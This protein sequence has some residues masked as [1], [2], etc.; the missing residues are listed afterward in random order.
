MEQ[1]NIT[2][3]IPIINLFEKSID[4]SLILNLLK[5][6]VQKIGSK[7]L[8][9]LNKDEIKTRITVLAIYLIY[10]LDNDLGI[11]L[12]AKRE[13]FTIKI[14]FNFIEMDEGTTN[15]TI[16]RGVENSRKKFQTLT[17]S[18]PKAAS[19]FVRI[20]DDNRILLSS[21]KSYKTEF[22]G[23]SR[24]FNDA[25]H[26]IISLDKWVPNTSENKKNIKNR[27]EFY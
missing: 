8:T 17:K 3:N 15:Y 5:N 21:V 14:P 24:F 20:L 4:N 9:K 23:K 26:L 19:F 16:F 22:S 27:P 12:P 1:N 13:Y 11:N 7:N 2:T 25:N 18:N 6:E 10:K